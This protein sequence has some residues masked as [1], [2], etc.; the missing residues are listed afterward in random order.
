VVMRPRIG[1]IEPYGEI[2]K[3]NIE[4]EMVGLYISGHPL[5]Q[6]KFEMKYFTNTKL[7]DLVD[8]ERLQGKEI[9]LGGMITEVAHLTTKKGKPYGRFKITG[10]SDSHEFFLFSPSYLD[11][12][13][14]LEKGWFIYM[15]GIVQNRW[16]G[17]DLE[18]KITS[19]EPL[20]DIRERMAKG[21]ELQMRLSD[22]SPALIGELE[23]YGQKYPGNN[24]FKLNI[25]GAFEERMIN[26]EMM[27][28]KISVD[29]NDDLIKELDRLEDISYRVL[30]S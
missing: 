25:M 19:M 1:K 16:S 15:T 27:S 29:I 28:R 11:F 17:T 10:Y 4:Q 30:T 20:S 21:I 22:V 2:E 5:D 8:L 13:A 18:F 7:S 26:L 23:R 12:K 9:K 24:V 3:L 14:Y 6:Y